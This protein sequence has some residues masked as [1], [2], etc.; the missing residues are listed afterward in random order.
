MNLPA[1]HLETHQLE[2]ARYRAIQLVDEPPTGSLVD[3]VQHIALGCANTAPVERGCQV[4]ADPLIRSQM[5]HH[6]F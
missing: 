5:L 3:E 2:R 6:W 4:T 1:F